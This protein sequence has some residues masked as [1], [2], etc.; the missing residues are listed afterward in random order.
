MSSQACLLPWATSYH[1]CP[2]AMDDNGTF[3]IPLCAPIFIF[4]STQQAESASCRRA[5]GDTAHVVCMHDR[6]DT[7]RYAT[8][9][10]WFSPSLPVRA[11]N[12]P[13]HGV[14]F[15][16][17]ANKGHPR[18]RT[19][20][21]IIQRQHDGAPR[22]AFLPVYVVIVKVAAAGAEIQAISSRMRCQLLSKPFP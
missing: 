9:S 12:K 5:L 22:A 20:H 4:P 7:I 14:F 13:L 17:P 10:L 3:P 18:R 6:L 15:L 8:T 2:G 16:I 19:N 21:Q 11:G 1:T